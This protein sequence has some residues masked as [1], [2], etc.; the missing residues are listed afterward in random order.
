[1][2]P[3]VHSQRSCDWEDCPKPVRCPH[4][5]KVIAKKNMFISFPRP[6]P[7]NLS[8]CT[9]LEGTRV[10]SCKY[11]G[12]WVHWELEPFQKPPFSPHP[13]TT[14]PSEGPRANVLPWDHIPW[15]TRP[16]DQPRLDG[17]PNTTSAAPCAKL[18]CM[19]C[20]FGENSQLTSPTGGG[21]RTKTSQLSGLWVVV[22]FSTSS[23]P[24][25]LGF[26]VNIF[27]RRGFTLCW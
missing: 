21:G 7:A 4:C 11:N 25:I 27:P 18:L 23:E 12:S 3:L 8:Y 16:L 17:L 26:A 20:G 1:M 14:I 24:G 22:E 2:C 5:A 9:T 13:R 15:T 6:I 19:S 10:S